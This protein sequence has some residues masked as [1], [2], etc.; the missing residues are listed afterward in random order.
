MKAGGMPNAC[1]SDGT[2]VHGV[3]SGGLVSNV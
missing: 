3:S 2:Y 1:K